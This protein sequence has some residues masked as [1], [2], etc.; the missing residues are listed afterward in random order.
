MYLPLGPCYVYFNDVNLG[1]TLKEEDTSL[2]IK[3]KTEDIK[4]DESLEIKEIIELCKEITFKTTLLLSEETLNNLRIDRTFSSLTKEGELRIITLDNSAVIFMYKVKLIAEPFFSFK[5]NKT[6]KIKVKAVALSNGDK[7]DIEILFGTNVSILIK[8]NNLI[9][10]APSHETM[11]NLMI[12]NKRLIHRQITGESD[13]KIVNGH[14][15][16]VSN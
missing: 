9:L 12:K 4:T 3:V 16:E 5:G 11:P 7:K 14:L 13:F 15:I 8:N 6:N 1:V 2:E 10:F